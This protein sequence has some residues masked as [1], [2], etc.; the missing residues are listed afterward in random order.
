VGRF[1]ALQ[2][3]DHRP[4]VLP[5][6]AGS[7]DEDVGR[8]VPPSATVSSPSVQRARRAKHPRHGTSA[9]AVERHGWPSASTIRMG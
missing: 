5:G 2:L 9:Q 8:C 7:E 1:S 3:A 4:A 6:P